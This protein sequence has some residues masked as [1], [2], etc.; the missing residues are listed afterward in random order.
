VTTRPVYDT[1]LDERVMDIW[2]SQS[3]KC[4]VAGWFNETLCGS[5]IAQ[6]DWEWY[7]RTS[8]RWLGKL[9]Q[10]VGHGSRIYCKR[11]LNNYKGVNINK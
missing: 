4:H 11:C 1:F 3:G 5:Y 6:P 10:G 8:L 9:A 2:K 7:D